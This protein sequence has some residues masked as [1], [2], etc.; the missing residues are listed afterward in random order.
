MY[1]QSDGSEN[2]KSHTNDRDIGRARRKDGDLPTYFQRLHPNKNDPIT[3]HTCK[4]SIKD[5]I[6]FCGIL[7]MC[8]VL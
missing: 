1:T 2:S 8:H 5:N 7:C 4:I 3:E 6:L